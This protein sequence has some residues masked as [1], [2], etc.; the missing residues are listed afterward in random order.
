MVLKRVR[1]PTCFSLKIVLKVIFLDNVQYLIEHL[2]A[3]QLRLSKAVYTGAIRAAV[4]NLFK[5][6]DLQR[7]AWKQLE[8]TDHNMPRGKPTSEFHRGQIIALH[9]I[10][11]SFR[12]ISKQLKMPKSTIND[13]IQK[14]KK[15]KSVTD[16]PRVGCPKLSSTRE[17][18]SLV[19]K[20]I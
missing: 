19:L 18:K 13:I 1:P 14:Y 11:L 16:E 3:A 4:I 20:S 12:A 10:K 8:K 5:I 6:L 7:G 17:D 9:Q 15:N 2:T